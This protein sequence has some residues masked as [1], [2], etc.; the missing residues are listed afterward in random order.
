MRASGW[1]VRLLN[2]A[3]PTGNSSKIENFVPLLKKKSG[4]WRCGGGGI[5][6]TILALLAVFKTI[7]SPPLSHAEER[8]NNENEAPPAPDKFN[9]NSLQLL[10]EIRLMQHSEE[11]LKVEKN[12]WGKKKKKLI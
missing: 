3:G 11:H 9:T 7:L 1:Q 5:S 10:L 12:C 6:Q 2:A 8:L 4:G